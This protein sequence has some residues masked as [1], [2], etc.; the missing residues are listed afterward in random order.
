[1][2]APASESS[3]EPR[4][5]T[6]PLV[7]ALHG[8]SL[9]R[10]G[11]LPGVRDRGLLESALAR[12]QNR[13]AYEGVAALPALAAIYGSA[14]VRNHPFLDGNKR[15][16]LLAVRAF[17]FANGLRFEPGEAETVAVVLTLASGE[18]DEDAFAAWIAAN[19]RPR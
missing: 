16:G 7:E 15:A 11:G 8:E 6:A 10:F 9:R 14:I 19:V 5:L 3:S 18:V 1:M 17:L 12:P 4:W 13:F 2:S